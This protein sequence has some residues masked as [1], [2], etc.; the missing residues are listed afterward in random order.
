MEPVDAQWAKYRIAKW[1]MPNAFANTAIDKSKRLS[2]ALEAESFTRKVN[3]ANAVWELIPNLGR[4]GEGSVAVFPNVILKLEASQAPRLEYDVSFSKAGEFT[5]QA[6]LIPT[7]PLTGTE[8]KFAVA[9]DDAVPQI[10]ALDVKDGGKEWAQ[11]VLNATRVA[12]TK[13]SVANAGK[14]TLKIYGVDAGVVLDKI[15]IDIDGLPET[16]LGL[17][18]K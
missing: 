15:V 12:T 4:T 14:H 18:A 3:S 13:I 10:V 11:G 6:Y 1:E 8:L 9:I 16:Y 7:H 17:P 5:L 2:F